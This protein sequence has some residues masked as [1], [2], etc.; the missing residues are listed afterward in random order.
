[1]WGRPAAGAHGLPGPETAAGQSGLILSRLAHGLPGPETAAGQ[2]GLA[3]GLPGPET[4]A[5][6]SGLILSSSWSTMS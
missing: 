2:S 4:A 6:Q 1:M 3:G 5:G